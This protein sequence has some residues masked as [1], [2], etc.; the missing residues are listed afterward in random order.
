[1][2]EGALTQK[3]HI[4]NH[5]SGVT[6]DINVWNYKINTINTQLRLCIVFICVIQAIS[7]IF[8]IFKY[9]CNPLL[10]DVL[11]VYGVVSSSL[12]S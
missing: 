12:A 6:E 11:V 3:L 2:P 5:R 9:I 7:G 8:I 4:S 10:I 1:M